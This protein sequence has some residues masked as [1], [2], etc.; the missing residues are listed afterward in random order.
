MTYFKKLIGIDIEWSEEG[1]LIK[2]FM[3]TEDERVFKFVFEAKEWALEILDI[4]E[5]E[6]EVYR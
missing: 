6:K 1:T 2:I 4:E 3:L 5:A